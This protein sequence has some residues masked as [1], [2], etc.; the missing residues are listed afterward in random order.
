M[1]DG[2]ERRKAAKGVADLKVVV[3]R[4]LKVEK[5]RDLR[6]AE[7]GVEAAQAAIGLRNIMLAALLL[8]CRYCR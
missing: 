4:G 3:V 1:L 5:A 7:R 8:W 2:F 6:A